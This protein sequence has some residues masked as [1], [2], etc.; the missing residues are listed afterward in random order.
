MPTRN[1]G[2]RIL[3]FLGVTRELPFDDKEKEDYLEKL[4]TLEDRQKYIFSH[5]YYS[6]DVLD[7]KTNSMIQFSSVI[8]AIFIAVTV[9]AD[10]KE[11]LK[12]W[13]LIPL[14]IG[15]ALSASALIFFL[16]VE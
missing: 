8:F 15:V 11:V 7:N 2:Q 6:L 3:E 4:R 13:L 10:D 12:G 9:Y 16:M 14:I 1:C 5:L